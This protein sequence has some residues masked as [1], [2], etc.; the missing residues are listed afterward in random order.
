LAHLSGYITGAY[1]RLPRVWPPL[2]AP[3]APSP[4]L[5]PSFPRA[6]PPASSSPEVAWSHVR[7]AIN[8]RS[9]PSACTCCPRRCGCRQAVPPGRSAAANFCARACVRRSHSAGASAPT[10]SRRRSAATDARPFRCFTAPGGAAQGSFSQQLS[11]A[12]FVDRYR[13]IAGAHVHVRPRLVRALVCLPAAAA[14]GT[15]GA[16][17]CRGAGKL[18]EAVGQLVARR[19]IIR[20]SACRAGTAADGTE[21]RLCFVWSQAALRQTTNPR[22]QAEQLLNVLVHTKRIGPSAVSLSAAPVASVPFSCAP[23]PACAV[24]RAAGAVGRVTRANQG[25]GLPRSRG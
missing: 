17:A 21:R 7:N 15:A 2:S 13:S 3:L 20:V 16:G 11:F 22:L 18:P 6:V 4:S 12:Q 8:V 24:G 19:T 23:A 10:L 5:L 25:D 14:A 9:L 1:T